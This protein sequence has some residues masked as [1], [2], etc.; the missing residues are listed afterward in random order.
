M[1]AASV[2]CFGQNVK[3]IKTNLP[4]I[5]IREFELNNQAHGMAGKSQLGSKEYI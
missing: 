1:T 5:C 2:S 4:D 3:P